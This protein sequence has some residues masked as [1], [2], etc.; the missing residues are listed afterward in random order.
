[1]HDLGLDVGAWRLGDEL[2]DLVQGG[3]V[4]RVDVL[5]QTR[6]FGAQVVSWV[7]VNVFAAKQFVD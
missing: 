4:G 5:T 2:E 1:M 3:E 6:K 7:R